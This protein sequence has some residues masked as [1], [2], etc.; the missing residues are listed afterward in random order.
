MGSLLTDH[1]LLFFPSKQPYKV[2]PSKES[3]KSESLKLAAMF[4]KAF[5]K[6]KADCKPEVIAAGPQ[7][8]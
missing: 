2:W 1:R 3:C 5:D 6:Y 4:T 8:E 7:I